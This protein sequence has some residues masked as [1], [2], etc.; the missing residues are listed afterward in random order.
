MAHFIRRL[1]DSNFAGFRYAAC[2]SSPVRALLDLL[3]TD[4]VFADSYFADPEPHLQALGIDPADRE[5][6]RRLD[7]HAVQLLADAKATEP[8]RAPEFDP[9][10]ATRRGPTLL[11]ATW[12]C[13]ASVV[14]WL[15]MD[16]R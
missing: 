13:V 12:C 1:A 6:L 9:G 16:G 4:R 11:I 8:D 15:L 2:M 10:Q 5:A 3:A 14:L 7:R